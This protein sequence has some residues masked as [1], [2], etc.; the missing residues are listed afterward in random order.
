MLKERWIRVLD[1]LA[2]QLPVVVLLTFVT[3]YFVMHDPEL[4]QYME[5]IAAVRSVLILFTFFSTPFLVVDLFVVPFVLM[6]T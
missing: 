1:I 3:A 4:G 2:G 6:N 5:P